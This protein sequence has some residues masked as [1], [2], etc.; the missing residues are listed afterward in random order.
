MNEFILSIEYNYISEVIAFINAYEISDI[1]KVCKFKFGIAL[2]KVNSG[3]M[4]EA[5]KVIID[6]LLN[7]K[8]FNVLISE[9]YDGCSQL[10]K[11][12]REMLE[13]VGM[14]EEAVLHNRKINS[15]T[16]RTENKV[17]YS[18]FK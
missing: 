4:E 13:N 2:K 10:T 12:K 8:K 16:G 17:I 11:I 3:Y 9:F 15:K 14:S 5:L 7:E 18:I 1:N 6:Y